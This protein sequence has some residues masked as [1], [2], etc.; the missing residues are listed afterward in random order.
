MNKQLARIC[1][2][3]QQ[4]V[5]AGYHPAQL[6]DIIED[7]IDTTNLD[8]ISDEQGSELIKVLEFYCNFS[9]KCKKGTCKK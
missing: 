4:L 6:H 7:A 2:L 8:H 5:V 1:E 3:K 9:N